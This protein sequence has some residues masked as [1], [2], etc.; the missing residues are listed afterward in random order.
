MPYLLP[1]KIKPVQIEDATGDPLDPDGHYVLYH[2]ITGTFRV[3]GKGLTPAIESA[4]RYRGDELFTSAKAWLDNF[5]AILDETGASGEITERSHHNALQA[6]SKRQARRLPPDEYR[7]KNGRCPPGYEFDD[8]AK[9]CRSSG[10]AKAASPGNSKG[11]SDPGAN[12]AAKGA[13]Y[14]ADKGRA[15]ASGSERQAF[16]RQSG[17]GDTS[18]SPKAPVNAPTTVSGTP[19]KHL[20]KSTK[21]ILGRLAHP[22]KK[23]KQLFTSGSARHKLIRHLETAFKRET[24]ETK[25][26][27]HT[28]GSALHGQPITAEEKTAAINQA[29]DLVKVSILGAALFGPTATV[30]LTGHISMAVAELALPGPEDLLWFLDK[31][32]RRL[33]KKLFGEKFEHGLTPSDQGI[34]PPNA[35]RK[36][37]GQQHAAKR[38]GGMANAFGPA[39]AEGPPPDQQSVV[40]A[41]VEPETAE[42][43]DPDHD[44]EDDEDAVQKW[45]EEILTVLAKEPPDEWTEAPDDDQPEDAPK[46]PDPNRGDWRDSKTSEE[47]TTEE[48]QEERDMPTAKAARDHFHTLKEI[49]VA[50]MKPGHRIYTKQYGEEGAWQ[51][52][53]TTPGGQLHA[54]PLGNDGRPDSDAKPVKLTT[55]HK[56]SYREGVS[57]KGY[58][59]FRRYVKTPNKFTLLDDKVFSL[60]QK[61]LDAMAKRK[62]KTESLASAFVGER[63][64][65]DI[66]KAK[67][68]RQAN[69]P[70]PEFYATQKLQALLPPN[71]PIKP[72]VPFSI[73]FTNALAA[74]AGWVGDQFFADP[75]RKLKAI[76][77]SGRARYKVKHH[78]HLFLIKEKLETKEMLRTISKAIHGQHITTAAR[79]AAIMQAVD[80][81]KISILAYMT[82]EDPT[83]ALVAGRTAAAVADLVIPGPP[84]VLQWFDKPIRKV[85]KKL[86]GQHFEFGTKPGIQGRT[87][88]HFHSLL[89]GYRKRAEKFAKAHPPQLLKHSKA[90]EDDAEIAPD[91]T[92]A[93]LRWLNDVVDVL[94]G[95]HPGGLED[96]SSV[97]SLATAFQSPRYDAVTEHGFSRIMQ[98]V[99]TDPDHGYTILSADR[100]ERSPEQ[101]AEHRKQLEQHLRSLKK[102]FMHVKGGYVEKGPD[103]K[104]RHVE[105]HSYFVPHTTKDEATALAKHAAEKHGQE[106]VMWGHSREG[107]HLISHSGESQK[108]GDSFTTHNIGDYFT[109]FHH[110]KFAFKEKPQAMKLAASLGME[111]LQDPTYKGNWVEAPRLKMEARAASADELRD[112]IRYLSAAGR[113]EP[114]AEM[115]LRI[116]QEE[117]EMRGRVS[118][119][120]ESLLIV[121]DTLNFEALEEREFDY[122]TVMIEL[123]GEVAASLRKIQSRLNHSD[124]DAEEGVEKDHHVTVKF[125]LHDNDPEAVR[126]VIEQGGIGPFDL[127][128]GKTSVF[129]NADKPDVVKVDVSSPELVKLNKLLTLNLPNTETYA[130]KPHATVAYVKSGSGQKYAGLDELEGKKFRVKSVLL[131]SKKGRKVSIPLGETVDESAVPSAGMGQSPAAR[132]T[133]FVQKAQEELGF[134]LLEAL[135][136]SDF[137][138]LY[139]RVTEEALE[140]AKAIAGQMTITTQ[141]GTAEPSGEGWRSI[142][143]G[144]LL[145][146]LDDEPDFT[147]DDVQLY[148]DMKIAGG[149]NVHDSI[150]LTREK[151]G[152]DS[153][154]VSPMGIVTS[155]NI[156]L[157]EPEPEQQPMPQIRPAS[158]ETSPAALAEK[159]QLTTPDEMPAEDGHAPE[160]DDA[161]VKQ[162]D[163]DDEQVGKKLKSKPR[164]TIPGPDTK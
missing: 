109:K 101:N 85:T 51:V 111:S 126:K 153:L 39:E 151:F 112:L 11:R 18:D 105:E 162:K 123:S 142:V 154:H 145:E 95:Q 152:L 47:P 49:T 122:S 148:F 48:E 14:G 16:P 6:K 144:R 79:D 143:R 26:M 98:H 70:G 93:A 27:V 129:K 75:F 164:G 44:E 66:L 149:E 35:A 31:P 38:Q 163:G 19:Y 52:H 121:S 137:M 73:K 89:H 114:G 45:L 23:V 1:T 115:R 159:P 76:L 12:G 59:G 82:Y 4:T 36:E 83:M 77:T 20:S 64:H 7:R 69:R 40:P 65:H 90:M 29:V 67:A 107:A 60:R 113:K 104:P 141:V 17:A 128:F 127:S 147:L 37:R 10:R 87:P 63:S 134:G 53:H 56:D 157:P 84:D 110:R 28:L 102:G 100:G 62:P 155:K 158:P 3:E 57:S 160:D 133:S 74:G 138:V 50:E 103:G 132:A 117:L 33:T 43:E 54:I 116:A 88:K 131:S 2:T 9:T 124:I 139:L 58:G 5:E 15:K 150:R 22:L 46:T 71:P 106:A 13:G 34:V 81:V 61:H 119:K 68:V 108:V 25:A 120:F 140:R 118:A 55:H 80:L 136:N 24:M 86:F 99:A 32:I 72:K 130:Y 8:A 30:A 135:Y 42:P 146:W 94:A 97:E 161:L 156:P 92:E 21:W 125:G 78:L 41:V 96:E 91:E